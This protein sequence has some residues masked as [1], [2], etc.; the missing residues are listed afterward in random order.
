MAL[1]SGVEQ[2]MEEFKQVRPINLTSTP[3]LFNSIYQQFQTQLSQQTSKL[4]S[5]ISPQQISDRRKSLLAQFK[6]SFGGREQVIA[7]GGAPSSPQVLEWIKECFQ[8]QVIDGFG[9]TEVGSIAMGNLSTSKL[10][11]QNFNFLLYQDGEI[12]DDTEAKLIPCPEIGYTL[13]DKPFPRFFLF[14]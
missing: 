9:A 6:N 3:S 14:F 10:A 1:S 13:E 2:L 4:S 7:V 5:Q 12:S 8:C 11:N